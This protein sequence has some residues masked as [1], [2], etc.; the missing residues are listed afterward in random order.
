MDYAILDKLVQLEIE[1]GLGDTWSDYVHF[2]DKLVNVKI[3]YI[4]MAVELLLWNYVG[5]FVCSVINAYKMDNF[6]YLGLS[7]FHI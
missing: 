1:Y 2:I 7:L 5:L 6:I 4:K 3:L